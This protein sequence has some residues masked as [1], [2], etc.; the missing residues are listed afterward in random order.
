M[1]A[2]EGSTVLGE[3]PRDFFTGGTSEG[4]GPTAKLQGQV[5]LCTPTDFLAPSQR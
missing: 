2:R 3:S 1:E 5:G 4:W